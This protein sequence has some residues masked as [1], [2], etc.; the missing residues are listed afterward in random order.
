MTAAMDMVVQRRVGRFQL[1]FKLVRDRPTDVVELLRDKIVIRCEH[2][3]YDD[4]LDYVAYG[5]CFV[6]IPLGSIAPLYAV[7]VEVDCIGFVHPPLKDGEWYRHALGAAS[8]AGLRQSTQLPAPPPPSA[9]ELLRKEEIKRAHQRVLAVGRV[10]SWDERKARH[11]KLIREETDV[12]NA[13]A[14]DTTVL[15]DRERAKAD[16]ADYSWRTPIDD[17]NGGRR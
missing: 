8:G 11:D 13:Y 15:L 14:G 2:L 6:S 9:M 3:A 17:R 16:K 4:V 7:E 10:D 1:P 5:S 12:P